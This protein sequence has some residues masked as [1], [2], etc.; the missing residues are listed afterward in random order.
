MITPT[1]HYKAVALIAEP[2]SRASLCAIVRS[3]LKGGPVRRAALLA[4]TLLA[5][6][7]PS[8]DPPARG[9]GPS[10]DDGDPC[11]EDRCVADRCVHVPAGSRDACSQDAHCDDADPCTADRCALDA[12]GL[13]RCEHTRSPGC[14]PCE[15]AFHCGDGD[16]CT[17]DRC[18]Q[19]ICGRDPMEGCDARCDRGRARGP[20]WVDPGATVVRGRARTLDAA[21]VDAS[22]RCDLVHVLSDGSGTMALS[23]D[24]SLEACRAAPCRVWGRDC[25]WLE[26]GREYFVWGEA[27]PAATLGGALALEVEGW[28]SAPTLA[29]AE[30]WHVAT[31]TLDGDPRPLA[32]E[33]RVDDAGRVVVPATAR[34]PEQVTELRLASLDIDGFQLSLSVDGLDLDV[35]LYPGR[36]RLV[37]PVALRELPVPPGA[38]QDTVQGPPIGRLEAVLGPTPP[39]YRPWP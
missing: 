29:G 32:L 24:G 9:C 21:C 28:C 19:G 4:L 7:G 8:L 6:D 11:T 34:S 23:Q 10:C 16:P 35:R 25:Q 12:C 1:L 20:R 3:T 15:V 5:C 27:R 26:L 38:P 14:A 31:L 36:D 13:P 2:W 30:G 33:L 39:P 17:I 37:G 22:C 18:V